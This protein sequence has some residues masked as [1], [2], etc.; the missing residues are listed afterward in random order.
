MVLSHRRRQVRTCLLEAGVKCLIMSSSRWRWLPRMGYQHQWARADK[1][2]PLHTG[3]EPLHH[4]SCQTDCTVPGKSKFGDIFLMP[5]TLAPV[6]VAEWSCDRWVATS[7]SSS[8]PEISHNSPP[9]TAVQS[10]NEFAQN[11]PEHAAHMVLIEDTLRAN[12]INK[13]P[14]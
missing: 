7:T 4:P 14:M 8:L 13:V 10:E 3:L 6:L 2:H 11:P 12:G 5:L 1:R 9:V